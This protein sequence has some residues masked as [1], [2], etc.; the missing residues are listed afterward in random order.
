MFIL[1]LHIEFR[2]FVLVDIRRKLCLCPIK[3]REAPG[4]DDGADL[5]AAVDLATPVPS[6]GPCP[7][8]PDMKKTLNL[9]ECP[10]EKEK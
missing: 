2:L 6:L 7:R 9:P 10:R 8:P 5:A 4:D 3:N 1:R